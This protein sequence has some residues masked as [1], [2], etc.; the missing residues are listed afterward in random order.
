MLEVF[1][2]W[3]IVLVVFATLGATARGRLRPRLDRV[4]HVVSLRP[5]L[6][7]LEAEMLR[8]N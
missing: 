1:Q 3:L 5:G 2:A 6:A 4:V 7:A 8:V